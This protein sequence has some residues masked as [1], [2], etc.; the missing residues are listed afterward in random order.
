MKLRHKTVN[1]FTLIELVMTIV[2]VGII[3]V[4]V[5]LLIGSHLDSA[6]ASVDYTKASNLA[7]LEMEKVNNMA[8]ANLNSLNS[9]YGDYDII[10]TVVYAQGGAATAESLKEISVEVMRTGSLDT[11]VQLKTYRCKNVSYGT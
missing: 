4:P 3:S 5:S 7:R 10:R 9:T 11:L 6:L 8:Y 1:A 2:V